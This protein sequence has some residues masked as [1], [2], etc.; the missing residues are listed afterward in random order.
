MK[1]YIFWAAAIGIIPFRGSRALKLKLKLKKCKSTRVS[2]H[3]AWCH[4][5]PQTTFLGPVP[6]TPRCTT[7]T[8]QEW[9]PCLRNFLC[10]SFFFCSLT[11][12]PLSRPV[13]PLFILIFH[14]L[15][16]ACTHDIQPARCVSFFSLFPDHVIDH[17]IAMC[18]PHGV[19]ADCLATYKQVQWQMYTCCHTGY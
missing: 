3:I 9:L 2:P 15:P 6:E 10:F 13:T 4:Q 18:L 5:H 1:H 7:G 11:H 16:C 17:L 19:R 8:C 12:I 14:P